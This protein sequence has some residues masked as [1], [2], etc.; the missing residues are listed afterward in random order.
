MFL[1]DVPL[2]RKVESIVVR[3]C[4]S[5]LRSKF[6]ARADYCTHVPLGGHRGEER[7]KDSSHLQWS[8]YSFIREG[9]KAQ[10]VTGTQTKDAACCVSTE[11]ASVTMPQ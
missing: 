10:P 8:M 7:E 6:F 2:K 4:G 9:L 3:G 5:T 1:R 11:G